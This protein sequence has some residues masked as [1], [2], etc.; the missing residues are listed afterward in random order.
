MHN[1]DSRWGKKK[2]RKKKG[3]R[4][5]RLA[6]NSERDERWRKPGG[7]VKRWGKSGSLH[8]S[9]LHRRPASSRATLMAAPLLDESPEGEKK[10]VCWGLS[11]TVGKKW[12]YSLRDAPRS[13]PDCC[14]ET[15][16]M[17]NSKSQEGEE[18]G[19]LR[20]WEK[21]WTWSQTLSWGR[22]GAW[23]WQHA[24][25]SHKI[26]VGLLFRCHVCRFSANYWSI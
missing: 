6:S 18:D 17:R 5:L 16:R 4:T 13:G 1:W 15:D 26:S 20:W 25:A 19:L 22:L 23:T 21:A 14:C 8:T 9:S 10:T 12:D 2:E 11:V 7:K 24:G 3:E